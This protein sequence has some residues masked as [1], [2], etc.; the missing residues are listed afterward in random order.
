MIQQ[1][2]I[3]NKLAY[4]VFELESVKAWLERIKHQV[5]TRGAE[6]AAEK[7]AGPIVLAKM[8]Q[9]GAATLVSD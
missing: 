5:N 8:K 2:V 3:R 1:P 4:M 7:L 6:E 9:T